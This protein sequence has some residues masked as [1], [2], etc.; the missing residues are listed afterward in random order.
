MREDDAVQSSSQTWNFRRGCWNN[1]QLIMWIPHGFLKRCGSAGS[2]DLLP[3]VL[4]FV[5]LYSLLPI[6]FSLLQTTRFSFQ[7]PWN[8]PFKFR[9]ITISMDL[10]KGRALVST[11]QGKQCTKY[12]HVLSLLAFW[13]WKHTYHKRQ[14]AKLVAATFWCLIATSFCANFC[15]RWQTSA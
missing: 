2:I 9:V 6:L 8:L 13:R 1:F 12:S 10:R 3:S 14:E 15:I 11:A 5:Q 7:Q 4:H